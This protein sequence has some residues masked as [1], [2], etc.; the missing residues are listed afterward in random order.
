MADFNFNPLP[1]EEQNLLMEELDDILHNGAKLPQET[2]NTLIMA[3]VRETYRCVQQARN[4]SRKNANAIKWIGA[5]LAIVAFII[6][7]QHGPELEWLSF[8]FP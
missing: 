5:G 8:L 4:Q 1:D 7:S 2:S 3:A 6:V